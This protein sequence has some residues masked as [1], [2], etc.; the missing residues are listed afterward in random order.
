M[1]CGNKKI[2]HSQHS[3]LSCKC[4]QFLGLVAFN[5]SDYRS[6]YDFLPLKTQAPYSEFKVASKRIALLNYLSEQKVCRPQV[7]GC[8]A[9]ENSELGSSKPSARDQAF[10]HGIAWGSALDY[11]PTE[12]F[13]SILYFGALLWDR[14]K[15]KQFSVKGA[16]HRQRGKTVFLIKS[17]R[18]VYNPLGLVSSLITGCAAISHALGEGAGPLLR[19]GHGVFLGC[20]QPSQSALTQTSQDSDSA[21]LSWQGRSLVEVIGVP[22]CCT[23]WGL[24]EFLFQF[25]PRRDGTPHTA[26]QSI[27]S[28][29]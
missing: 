8:F 6:S 28:R 19:H 14:P 3:N 17:D 11:A 23:S 10:E 5:F 13:G 27:V 26:A 22:H 2:N 24:P 15:N 20:L 9:E 29:D 16:V 12:H 18:L 21:Q 25:M 1:S 4:L 7:K